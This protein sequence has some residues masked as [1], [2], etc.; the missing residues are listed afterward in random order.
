MLYTQPKEDGCLSLYWDIYFAKVY[1]E[2]EKCGVIGG[3]SYVVLK[4]TNFRLYIQQQNAF[5]ICLLMNSR[6]YSFSQLKHTICLFL[7]AILSQ[8]IIVLCIKI[9]IVEL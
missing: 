1:K 2:K 7:F 5:Y 4:S 6:L 9:R 3:I 8:F